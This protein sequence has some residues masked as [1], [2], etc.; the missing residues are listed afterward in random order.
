M[1]ITVHF[2]PEANLVII[3]HV[4]VVPD[5]EFLASYRAIYEDPRFDASFDELIDLRQAD[6]T[7]RSSCVLQEFAVFVREKRRNTSGSPRVVS[8]GFVP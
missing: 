2:H 1:P 3:V 4:G 8:I 6:S 7:P 5:D